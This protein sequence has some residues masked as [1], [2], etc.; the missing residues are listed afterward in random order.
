[1]AATRFLSTGLNYLALA[2]VCLF[3]VFPMYWMLKGSLE[4]APELL[5]AHLLPG[6]ISSE[7][8]RE[9]IGQASFRQYFFNSATVAIASTIVSTTCAVLAGYGLA[10]F[11]FPGK[12]AMSRGVLF[13][14]MFP[15]L[16]LSIPLFN[17]F[18]SIRLG[19]TLFGLMLTHVT[20][21]L[22]FGI[23]LMW[24]YFQTIPSAF[25]ENAA[26]LGAGRFRTFLEVELPLARSGLIAVAIFAFAL[27]WEE[28]EFAFVLI[29]SEA[30]KTLPIGMT[31]FVTRDYVV[32]NMIMA[33]G[34]TMAVPAFLLISFLQKYLVAGFTSGGL[35]G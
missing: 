30:S 29:T 14:Y 15:S 27:S 21:S 24:Q 17:I 1:M 7:A 33:A 28:Y 32:W 34:I 2:A 19:N 13:C 5:S 25:R 26:L 18:Y 16:A 4:T 3:F 23:W 35:K 6:S 31:Q 12:A 8:F 9:L 22:P 11:K 10:R 20:L